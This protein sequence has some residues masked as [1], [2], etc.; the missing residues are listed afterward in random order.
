MAHDIEIEYWE[1][2]HWICPRCLDDYIPETAELPPP[3]LALV[4]SADHS[5]DTRAIWGV[6]N[7]YDHDFDF[8]LWDRAN[9]TE[10]VVYCRECETVFDVD[11]VPRE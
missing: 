1:R 9:S 3:N 11:F 7:D 5:I 10:P 8:E 4:A 6:G 2:V